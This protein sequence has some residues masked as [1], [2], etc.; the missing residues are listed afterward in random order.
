[1]YYK[2]FKYVLIYTYQMQCKT[3]KPKKALVFNYTTLF[4]CR[5]RQSK[6]HDVWKRLKTEREQQRQTHPG[7]SGCGLSQ[8]VVLVLWS[9]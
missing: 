9:T 1:M 4:I 2:W 7:G 3:C 5:H 8:V 6:S